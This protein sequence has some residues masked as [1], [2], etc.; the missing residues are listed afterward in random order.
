[1]KYFVTYKTEIG[2]V[3]HEFESARKALRF[4]DALGIG[5]S[6]TAIKDETGEKLD[7]LDLKIRADQ[8]P[9]LFR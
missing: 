5:A 3:Q 8:K 1:M 2:P 4:L 6:Q 7:T 9:T